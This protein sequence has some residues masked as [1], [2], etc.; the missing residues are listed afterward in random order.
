[1][2]E[3]QENGQVT[4][5]DDLCGRIESLATTRH[6]ENDA[7]TFALAQDVRRALKARDSTIVELTA[8][9]VELGYEIASSDAELTRLRSA[10]TEIAAMSTEIRRANAAE[11]EI[12]KRCEAWREAIMKGPHVVE[13]DDGVRLCEWFLP[14][15]R[16]TVWIN[17]PLPAGSS[18]AYA[19]KGP[20]CWSGELRDPHLL[21]E[22]DGK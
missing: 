15:A 2:D 21:R 16:L 1:V 9:G 6:P 11:A 22:G 18:W 5:V 13:C 10:Q 3:H 7:V 17:G 20:T 8:A 19:D 4:D 12:R 14:D